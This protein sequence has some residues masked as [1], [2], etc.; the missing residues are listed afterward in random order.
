MLFTLHVTTGEIKYGSPGLAGEQRNGLW[1]WKKVGG[2]DMK[3]PDRKLT[4]KS[5]EL[6]WSELSQSLK[7]TCDPLSKHHVFHIC[8]SSQYLGESVPRTA[9]CIAPLRL[10][11]KTPTC[12][13]ELVKQLPNI[14]MN[15][16][17][18]YEEC[19]TISKIYC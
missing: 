15:E 9:A 10:P 1:P 8:C 16:A 14:T 12:L 19:R 13:Q 7:W 17:P 4:G 5:Q 18:F 6:L 2:Q 3:E 11:S